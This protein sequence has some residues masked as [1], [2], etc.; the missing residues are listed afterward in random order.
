[1]RKGCES[2]DVSL[3]ST[4]QL[5]HSE[6]RSADKDSCAQWRSEDAAAAGS[7]RWKRGMGHSTPDER[8]PEW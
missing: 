4:R 8:E 6:D 1:M 7:T 3:W 2:S 5:G